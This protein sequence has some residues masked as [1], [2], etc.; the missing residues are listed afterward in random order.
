M[1][2]RTRSA[3]RAAAVIVGLCTGGA[4]QAEAACSTLLDRSVA[5]LQDERPQSLCQYRSKVP[6]VALGSP[7]NDSGRYFHKHRVGRDGVMVRSH[8]SFTGP[9]D[10]GFHKQVEPLR[11][12]R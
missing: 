6:L 7:F 2:R 11:A 1:L 8:T 10:P 9:A 5:R 4:V 12:T 3:G